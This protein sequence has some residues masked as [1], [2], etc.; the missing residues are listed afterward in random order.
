MELAKLSVLAIALAFAQCL[1][2]QP[3]TN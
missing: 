1:T 3:Q 2:A